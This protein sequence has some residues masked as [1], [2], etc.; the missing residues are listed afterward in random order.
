MQ[1]GLS[2]STWAGIAVAGMA[3]HIVLFGLLHWLEPQLSPKSAIFSDY[4]KTRSSRIVRSALVAF[5]AMWLSM[6][7]VLAGASPGNPFLASGRVLFLLAVIGMGIAA[8]SPSSGDPRSPTVLAKVQNLLARP[9][10]FL[11]VVLVSVGL[12]GAS[13]WGDLWPVLLVLSLATAAMLPITIG[14]L[15]ERGLGGVGQRVIFALL[16]AWVVVVATRVLA[17]AGSR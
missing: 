7:I 11:G 5:A 17:N 14:L 8:F 9:G 10:L 2:Q 3:C 15:L 4:V 1:L 12:R 16:Y 6:A 13:G